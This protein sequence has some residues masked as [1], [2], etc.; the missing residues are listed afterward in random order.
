MVEINV[1]YLSLEN[2]ILLPITPSGSSYK[3]S[4]ENFLSLKNYNF[5]D[6]NYVIKELKKIN[7]ILSK[8]GELNYI[9]VIIYY[10]KIN[11]NNYFITSILLK[12]NT[13][14]PIKNQYMNSN[15]FKKYGLS[16]EY[17]S[18][19]ELVDNTILNKENV[20]DESNKGLG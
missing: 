9:P 4:H 1:G 19:E 8:S 2:G 20:Q 6:I 14:I 15:Q 12:N 3:Y 7:S 10:N 11:K 5:K 13:I 16:Y 18:Q 17:Q